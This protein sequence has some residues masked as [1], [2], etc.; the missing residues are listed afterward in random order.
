MEHEASMS[1]LEPDQILSVENLKTHFVT[2]HGTVKA[3]DDASF[4][5]RAGQTLAI[6]GESG[7]GKSITARSILRLVDPPGRIV[8]GRILLCGRDPLE[9][10]IDLT[11]LDPDGPVMSAIRGRDVGLVFQEPM[12][13]LS[14]QYTIGNQM[15]E[16]IRL[17]TSQSKAEARDSAIEMLKRVEIP[18]S[19]RRM[20]DRKSVV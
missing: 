2:D 6:V 4:V 5:V 19:A 20:K 14:M 10:I 18:S 1:P 9:P 13:S 8:G 3:V 16:A 15:T 12:A 17:H 7:C 11:Q